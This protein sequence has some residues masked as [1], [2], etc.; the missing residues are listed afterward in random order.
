[1]LMLKKKRIV[2]HIPWSTFALSEGD[3]E[4]VKEV[5]EILDMHE[6]YHPFL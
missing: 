4:R 5:G 3:W 2:K 6:C 1:M